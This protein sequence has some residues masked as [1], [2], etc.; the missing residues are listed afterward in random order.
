MSPLSLGR[1]RSFWQKLS[2][3]D[4]VALLVGLLYLLV[5]GLGAAGWKV[6]LRG[7]IGFLFFLASAYLL[8]RL[9][10][11][12][13]S[14]LLWGLRNRLIIAY[15]FIAVVPVLLLMT[16]AGLS[17]YLIYSQLGAH[18]AYDD[19]QERIEKLASTADFLA[20]E[21]SS[22]GRRGA[23]NAATSPTVAQVVAAA[24]AHMPGLQMEVSGEDA[25]LRA[26]G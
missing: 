24:G 17:A 16:M 18:L 20:T 26:Y 11:L 6:P 12:V 9:V 8:I 10:G 21:L 14:R 15:V 1:L 23:S 2:R 13:R 25:I 22:E 4:R 5:W 7:A 19:L 3:L